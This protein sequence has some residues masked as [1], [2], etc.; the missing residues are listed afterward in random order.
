MGYNWHAIN[1]IVNVSAICANQFV[2]LFGF[3]FYHKLETFLSDMTIIV[4]HLDTCSSITIGPTELNYRIRLKI[5]ELSIKPSCRRT[6]TSLGRMIGCVD[7]HFIMSLLCSRWIVWRVTINVNCDCVS[8]LVFFALP[9]IHDCNP[10]KYTSNNYG[11]CF[12]NVS[13]RI[14]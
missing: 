4:E 10:V 2:R 8:Q 7:L 1:F 12:V 11:T 6:F 9:L 14:L 5:C 13:T 3:L